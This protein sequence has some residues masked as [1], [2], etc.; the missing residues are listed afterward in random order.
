MNCYGMTDIGK[1]RETNQD[2]FAA[3]S[4]EDGALSYVLT[5]CDGMGGAN[6]GEI[7]SQKALEV[8]L[9][10]LQS[11]LKDC[12]GDGAVKSALFQSVNLA[13]RA[14][15]EAA[16]ADPS[17]SGMGTTLVSAVYVRERGL[18]LINVGDSRAYLINSKEIKQISHDHSYVQH[19]V[20][21]GELSPS[22]AANHPQRNIIMRAVGISDE[23]KPDIDKINTDD[24]T[25]L[26]LCS[27]GLH[28]MMKDSDIK[29][30]VTA[31]AQESVEEKVQA[32]VAL[33]NKKGGNDNITVVL[34]KLTTDE[35]R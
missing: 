35:E 26:L 4:Y 9:S 2:C 17:L 21:I 20:D 19:L 7:A 15:Y 25:Y 28:G 10:S 22:K 33:A 23:I 30:L 27:D 18:Y 16:D 5:V 24:F 3:T 31:K 12:D 8:Y 13:N 1:R 32:L 11:E 34:A 29:K 6:G 14:V